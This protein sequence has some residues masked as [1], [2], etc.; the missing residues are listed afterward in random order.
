MPNMTITDEQRAV[1]VHVI[2]TVT[3]QAFEQLFAFMSENKFNIINTTYAIAMLTWIITSVASHRRVA[4]TSRM[5]QARLKTHRTIKS[6]G[7]QFIGYT[8]CR[9]FED[10][11]YYVGIIVAYDM[12]ED[13]EHGYDWTIEY[14]DGDTETMDLNEV[15][16]NLEQE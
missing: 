11:N 12:P 5:L 7:E 9:K 3:S 8:T 6:L 4:E 15:L 2:R 16:M 14:E 1:C 13:G 10:G